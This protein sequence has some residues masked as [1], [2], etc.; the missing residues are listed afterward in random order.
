[1]LEQ[2]IQQHF[3]D[4]ADLKYQAAQVMSGPIAYAVGALLTCVTCGGKVL[5]C[6]T[7]PSAA[8]AHLF[9][10]LCV[11]GFERERPEL[12]ALALEQGSAWHTLPSGLVDT[13]HTLARQVRALG[14][15]GDV[16][17]IIT[18][19]G[20]EPTLWAAATAAHEREMTVLALTGRSGGALAALL[21]ET[22][23]LVR[24]PDERPARVR[25]V[26]SLVLHCLC[27]GVD[28]ELLGEQ[29]IA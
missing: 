10:A 16:L 12:A 22:D 20:E 8:Q 11:V 14:Q 5:T 9:A 17:L 7:G 21:R 3:V 23:V 24:V 26:H 6:G 15:P 19:T 18:V 25:E 13:E 28:S 29:E 2:R 27:D 4:S 1:M